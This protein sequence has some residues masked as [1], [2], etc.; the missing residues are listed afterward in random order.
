MGELWRDLVEVMR[1]RPALW[2]PVL[3]ADLLGYLANLGRNGLLRAFVLHQ[4]AQQSVLG[5]AVVHGPMTASTM[6][7]TTVLALLLSWFTYFL[8]ILLYAGALVAT[9]AL[10]NA[11]L[12]RADKPAAAVGPA[13][14]R[15]WSTILELTL[16]ALAVYAVAALLMSW[17]SPALIKYGQGA[18][19]KNFW[20]ALALSLLVPAVLATLV[21]PVA[22]RLL[23]GRT[24][25]TALNKLTQHFAYVLVAVTTF[26]ATVVS[27]NSRALAQAGPAARYPLEIIGS[28]MVALPY[29]LLFVGLSLLARRNARAEVEA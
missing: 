29:A 7:S 18:L 28:W 27:A 21:A 1:R 25:D 5:G 13:M 24:I 15:Q 3:M 22:V 14:Q 11:Y 2:L 23:S 26:L 19:L 17:V 10:V 12:D 9:A 6:E 16:R 4:T 8:R 20:F